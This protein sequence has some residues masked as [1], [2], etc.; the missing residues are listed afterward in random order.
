MYGFIHHNSRRYL[1]LVFYC[2]K[3]SGQKMSGVS[4][5]TLYIKNN[6]IE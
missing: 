5:T 3:F 6:V 1:S 2:M 4:M